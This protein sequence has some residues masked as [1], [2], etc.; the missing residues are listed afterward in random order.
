M[1]LS[2]RLYH[3]FIRPKWFTQKYIHD[4]ITEH[5]QLENKKV[6]DFGSGTGAIV[7]FAIQ[8][9]IQGSSLM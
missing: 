7:Q 2:P 4:H 3:S 9:Y 5:F 6:L 8:P 1:P